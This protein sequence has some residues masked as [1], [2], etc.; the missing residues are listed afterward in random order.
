M[1]YIVIYSSNAKNDLSELSDVISYDYK[2]PLTSF[3]YIRELREKI[4]TLKHYPESNAI[5]TSEYYRQFG[6]NTRRINYKRMAIIYT[7][8][9]DT[10]YIHRIVPSTTITGL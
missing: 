8:H 9:A 7:I 2:S 4:N 10:V 5:R 1:K 6:D 3:R